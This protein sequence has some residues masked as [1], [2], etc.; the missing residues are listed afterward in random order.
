M[1]ALAFQAISRAAK[2]MRI[3]STRTVDLAALRFSFL[4]I[5]VL[6]FVLWNVSHNASIVTAPLPVYPYLAD[7]YD[8]PACWNVHLWRA[9]YSNL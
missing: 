7:E 3:F 2:F 6:K 1:L 9:V 4:S 8:G 5:F